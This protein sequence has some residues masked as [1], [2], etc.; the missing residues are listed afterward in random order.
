VEEMSRTDTSVD[1]EVG[2]T[3]GEAGDESLELGPEGM[4]TG[5]RKWKERWSA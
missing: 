2:S 1:V 4:A 3:L 5:K